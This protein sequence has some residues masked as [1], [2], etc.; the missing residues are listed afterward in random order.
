MGRSGTNWGQWLTKDD[1]DRMS[2]DEIG[3]K[4]CCPR[5]LTSV[6][7]DQLPHHGFREEAGRRKD[8]T[9]GRRIGTVATTQ[10]LRMDACGHKQAINAERGCALEIGTDRVSYRE[11]TLACARMLPRAASARRNAC[12]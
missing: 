3:R 2:E 7:P 8:L 9:K 12:S 11:D 5:H 4:L 10:F 1:R 6:L